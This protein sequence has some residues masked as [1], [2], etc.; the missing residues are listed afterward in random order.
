M[1]PST[2]EQQKAKVGKQ[3]SQ[4]ACDS[5][6]PMPTPETAVFAKPGD[7]PHEVPPAAPRSPPM[8]PPESVSTS[9]EPGEAAA[10]A[11]PKESSEPPKTEAKTEET[12][13]QASVPAPR[14]PPMAPPEGVST[15]PEARH[16]FL[17]ESKYGHMHV[18]E[19][20]S[21]LSSLGA[22][23]DQIAGLAEKEELVELLEQLE[24]KHA[25]RGGA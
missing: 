18:Q 19:L 1:E 2:E 24:R 13:T 22:G 9:Q 15:S 12:S 21:K 11:M 8:V 16:K 23:P 25:D 6:A 3:E 10:K 4:G 5:S 7:K 17:E 14:S 20:K